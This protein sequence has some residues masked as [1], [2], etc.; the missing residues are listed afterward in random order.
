MLDENYFKLLE[1]TFIFAAAYLEENSD[2]K[3]RDL[4]KLAK[5]ELSLISILEEYNTLKER[6]EILKNIN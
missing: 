5:I 3:D 2:N 1:Q 6:E 4:E